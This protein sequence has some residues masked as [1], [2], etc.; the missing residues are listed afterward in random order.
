MKSNFIKYIFFII[1]IIVMGLAIYKLNKEEKKESEENQIVN[2]ISDDEQIKE[3]TL[4]IAEYDNINPILSNNKYIQEISKIIY[5]SLLEIDEEYK[6][7]TSLA[8]DWAK[9]S[10]TTY[11][12]KIRDDVKWSDGQPLTVDDVIYTIDILKRTPSIYAYNVQYITK[13]D[14]IDESTIQLTLDH[15]I[16]FFEYNLIFPIMSRNYYQEEDFASSSKN[17]MTI[18]TGKYKITQNDEEGIIL[19]KN[20][21]YYEDNLTLETIKI[22]KYSNLG[23]LYNAFKLG[24]VDVITTDSVNIQNYIGTIGY[25]IK[26]VA[27]REYEFLAINTQNIILSH[28]EVRKAISCAINKENIIA[29]I[30]NNKYKLAEY[31]LDYGN[32]LKGEGTNNTYSIDKAREIL[33]TSGWNYK[34]NKWQKVENYTT[35]TINLKLVVQA[36]NQTR[37]SV[38][39]MIKANL[40]ELG[41]NITIIKA[42]DAQYQSYLQ[43]RNY[44]MILTGTT[45]SAS[46]N[47][48]T[49][50]G[51]K[52]LA[53]YNNEEVKSI[54]SEVKNITKE[55]LLK[56]KYERLR[57]I[58]N[59]EIPYIGLYNSYYAVA[60]NWNLKGNITAN[61]Y[62]IFMDINNWYKN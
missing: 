7:R 6:I 60:S 47:L 18:G 26:E 4:G 62:N 25:N 40:A 54:I 32:Y 1:V 49:Y 27:G 50:F 34:N 55:S 57:Q 45:E 48:E 35:R 8:K 22:E 17:N 9:T 42:S 51:E 37:M 29:T 46:P 21:N 11:L 58:Y 33:E 41:I 15:E 2:E 38:A 14:K 36:T 61:W 10:E 44:D 19:N 23:E 31:P 53:N 52:N 3:I 39:E 43:N 24:K 13:I 30:Y 56:E 28:T 12:L 59:E 5:D 20:E 16:A